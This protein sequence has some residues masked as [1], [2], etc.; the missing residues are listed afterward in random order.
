MTAEC[1]GRSARAAA[2]RGPPCLAVVDAALERGHEQPGLQ[3]KVQVHR[4][5]FMRVNV[6]RGRARRH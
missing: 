6:R 5:R 4:L 1:Q 3:R 2:P